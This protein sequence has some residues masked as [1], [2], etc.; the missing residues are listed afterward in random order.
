MLAMEEKKPLWKQ[1]G[2]GFYMLL[3][4]SF[5]CPILIPVIAVLAAGLVISIIITGVS[6]LFNKNHD[7]DI[8]YWN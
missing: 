5:F 3:A 4:V 7:P 8:D 6:M 2:K 1:V